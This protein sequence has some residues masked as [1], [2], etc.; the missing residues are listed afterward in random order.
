MFCMEFCIT[1]H[2]C[3]LLQLQH[4]YEVIAEKMSAPDV[5]YVMVWEG[6]VKNKRIERDLGEIV[7]DDSYLV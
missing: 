6:A 7:D 3:Y 1:L 5:A 2:T 4:Y